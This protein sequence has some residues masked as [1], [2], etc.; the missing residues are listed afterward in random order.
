MAT[1]SGHI[2]SVTRHGRRFR[3]EIILFVCLKSVMM[4]YHLQKR[5]DSVRCPPDSG[6]VRFQDSRQTHDKNRHMH[7]HMSSRI[8]M[9]ETVSFAMSSASLRMNCT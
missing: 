2:R 8:I 7:M 5:R 4:R 1:G 3:M 9:L 6:D